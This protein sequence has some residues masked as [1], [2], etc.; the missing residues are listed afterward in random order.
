VNLAHLPGEVVKNHSEPVLPLSTVL[1][2]ILLAR[3]ITSPAE[4]PAARRRRRKRSSEYLFPSF[5]RKKPYITDARDLLEG[6]S[7]VAG[8]HVTIHDLR[9]TAEDILK[10][11]RVD[12]DDRRLLLNHVAEDVHG[13]H[14]SNNADPEILRPV[15]EAMARWVLEQAAIAIRKSVTAIPIMI[16][17]SSG[18]AGAAEWDRKVTQHGVLTANL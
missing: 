16:G 12:P 8:R 5:G 4:T 17:P 15:V 2:E 18:C 3:L 11:C 1:Y 14:C 7:K 6:V 10:F 9:R 13:T